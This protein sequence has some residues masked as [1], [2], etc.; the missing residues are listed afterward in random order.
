MPARPHGRTVCQSQ[1]VW[2]NACRVPSARARVEGR[3]GTDARHGRRIRLGRRPGQGSMAVLHP[4]PGEDR[5]AGPWACGQMAD[6]RGSYGFLHRH[7]VVDVR[8][9]GN[10]GEF[11]NSWLVRCHDPGIL[12]DSPLLRPRRRPLDASRRLHRRCNRWPDGARRVGMRDNPFPSRVGCWDNTA[13]WRCQC[14]A[15][16]RLCPSC[17]RRARQVSVDRTGPVS[18]PLACRSW[19]SQQS[20]CMKS[21]GGRPVCGISSL[22]ALV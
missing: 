1:S 3:V 5:P 22:P 12:P 8:A 16:A 15:C 18:G 10:D 13:C 2:L 7:Y 14:C 4:D 19:C 9:L 20:S 21:A 11:H 17:R 6:C